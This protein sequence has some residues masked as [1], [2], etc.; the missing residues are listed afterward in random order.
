M[1]SS[2]EMQRAMPGDRIVKLG[3]RGRRVARAAR[4]RRLLRPGGKL[5]AMIAARPAH[6]TLATHHAGGRCRAVVRC[7][8]G[9]PDV[10]SAGTPRRPGLVDSLSSAE[11]RPS[12]IGAAG[13]AAS[14][15]P[16]RHCPTM[17]NYHLGSGLC[18][19][20]GGRA[21]RKHSAEQ[22][23][24]QVAGD[25][26]SY[27]IQPGSTRFRVGD[28]DGAALRPRQRCAWRRKSRKSG[29]CW[30]MWPK[31]ATSAAPSTFCQGRRSGRP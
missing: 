10:A 24:A 18:R 21:A 5:G 31:A 20:A 4:N 29:F 26:A 30:A 11:Q 23:Q 14:R 16:C 1:I 19:A 3:E 15:T 12:R 17:L 27:Q 9:L 2:A 7:R 8:L 28:I 6:S 13:W 22:A 25:E